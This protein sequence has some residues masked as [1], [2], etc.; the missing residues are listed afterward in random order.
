MTEKTALSRGVKTAFSDGAALPLL[1]KPANTSGPDGES[2]EMT[3]E[4]GI[5]KASELTPRDFERML[6]R[7]LAAVKKGDFRARMPV[8]FT[9][10]AGKIADTLNEII[11]LNERTAQ[12][13]AR[14]ANVVGKE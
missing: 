5:D 3:T 10:T 13:I 6:L 9:G 1:F 14:I 7:T 4:I 8:E 12:E 2:R 11:E